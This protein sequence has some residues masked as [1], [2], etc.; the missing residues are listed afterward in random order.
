VPRATVDG[1]QLGPVGAKAG[2][3]WSGRG[4]RGRGVERDTMLELATLTLAKRPLG[5]WASSIL[6]AR[7]I[8]SMTRIR[9]I[10]RH[11]SPSIMAE[12]LAIDDGRSSVDGGSD[13]VA[14]VSGALASH[15]PGRAY[16]HARGELFSQRSPAASSGVAARATARDLH[17]HQLPPCPRGLNARTPWPRR[18]CVC[19]QDRRGWPWLRASECSAR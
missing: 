3:N 5:W 6:A 18:R 14:F 11:R 13:W 1:A 2:G 17:K 10:F 4:G 19:P 7:A 12:A 15:G 16:S 9:A 8:E